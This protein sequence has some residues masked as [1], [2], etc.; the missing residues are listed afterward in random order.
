M[1]HRLY[2][3]NV[4]HDIL[5][6]KMIGEDIRWRLE[7]K[8]LNED[9]IEGLEYTISLCTVRQ[10]QMFNARYKED[11]TLD[12][13]GD[14]LGITKEDVRQAINCVL[15]KISIPSNLD[16]IIYGYTTNF[17]RGKRVNRNIFWE[18]HQNIPPLRFSPRTYNALQRAG[19]TTIADLIYTTEDEFYAIPNIG[20]KCVSEIV[21]KVSDFKTKYGR[22]IENYSEIF[23]LPETKEEEKKEIKKPLPE[24]KEEKKKIILIKTDGY[25]I[26][27]W[28]FENYEEGKKEMDKQYASFDYVELEEDWA[29][30]SY[31]GNY[32]AILY[33]N[34]YGVYI[35][36]IVEIPD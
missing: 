13:I 15:R 21:S 9:Q 11:K 25:S 3:Y 30:M 8:V 5:K 33:C 24:K 27:T 2:P 34:S 1:T 10:Q 17:E 26:S 22:Y 19:K 12:A 6:N 28:T 14:S 29:E 20:G 31:C 32:D 16:F 36:K 18:H 23:F 35:W 4:I 7:G